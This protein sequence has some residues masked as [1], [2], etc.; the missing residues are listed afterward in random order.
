MAPVWAFLHHSGIRLCLDDWLIQASSREQ[1]L[2]ALDAVLQLCSSLGI[3]VNWEKSYLVPTQWM[4]YLVVLLHSLLQ[5]FSCP[6]MSREAS[7][8]W[9]SILVLLA[10]F[11]VILAKVSRGSVIHNS[12]RSGRQA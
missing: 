6:E 11:R 8:N 3:V 9:R 5:G 2:V 7:L 4:V 1:V 10:T 12:V